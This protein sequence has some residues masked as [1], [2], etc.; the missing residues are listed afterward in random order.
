MEMAISIVLMIIA[1]LEIVGIV[2]VVQSNA[3]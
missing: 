3:R 2:R 1:V